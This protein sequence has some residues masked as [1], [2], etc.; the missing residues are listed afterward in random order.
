ME[1]YLMQNIKFIDLFAGIGGFRIGF[2]QNDFKCCFSAEINDHACEMYKLN[3]LQ[4]PKCD[5]TQLSTETIPNFDVLCAGF[6]CQAFSIC[7]KQLGFEDTRGTLFFDICRILKDKKPRV[8]ILENVFNLINHDKGNTFN[9]MKKNLEELGYTLSYQILNARDFGVPQNRER[10]III[11]NKN[12]LYFDFD[13]L[14]RNRINSMREFLDSNQTTDNF[15]YLNSDD[16]TII[17]KS[18]Q[19]QQL[20]SGLLFVGYRNKAI[21]KTGVRPNTEHLSR[22]HKQPNRI[23]SID[24]TH[25]TL[26]SQEVNGRYWIYDDNQI[27]E[28]KVRKL[29]L[30]ECYRFMGFPNNYKKIGTSSQLY[31]RIGNSICVSMVDAIAKEIKHQFF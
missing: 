22:V 7:G 27:N 30:N 1:G 28:K 21:R 23:Y 11:G 9:V 19:K 29:S 2:E 25:P 12:N 14:S 6:P 5:I 8:F 3:F 16:Y 31:E 18:Y 10:L 13:K 26:A 4:N 15:E 24:G 20:K 17:D